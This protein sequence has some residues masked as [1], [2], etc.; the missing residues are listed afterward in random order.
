MSANESYKG[1]ENFDLRQ[2][3]LKGKNHRLAER[4]G[5]F[6][7]YL[8]SITESREQLFMRRILSEA[9]RSVIVEDPYTLA[10]KTMLMFG[11]N[12]YLGLAGH[13]YVKE[14]AR[15]ALRKYGA[16]VGGPPLLN[17][18]TALHHELEERLA[19]LKGAESAL[20]FSSGY[21]ANVGLVTGLVNSTDRVI[22]DA[23]SHASFCDG[24]RMSGVQS[25]HFPH[26]DIARA[27]DLLRLYSG[28]DHDVFVGV[29]GVYSMD[30][31]LA[32][33]DELTRM[34]RSRR[35]ILMVDDAHGTGVMGATGRGTAEHFG[36]EGKVDITMGTFSKAF[37]STGGF[38]ASSKPII[39]YLRFFARS[40]M[41]SAS[42]PPVVIATVLAG[43][44]VIE[45]EPGRIVRLRENLRH[46]VSGLNDMGFDVH[47]A[48]PIIPLRVPP[49]MNI[50]RAAYK[51]HEQ[52]IFMN[53]VEFPAVP[54]CQQRFR[55][56]LM[57]TH[58]RED[59]DR[60][61]RAVGEVWSEC[62][63]E[64]SQTREPEEAE[65]A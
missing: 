18:Y 48:A 57:A 49:G 53:S 46:A 55:I 30:G 47:P 27:E 54:V 11:S 3:L 45:R 64:A 8:R 29:E 9:G 32:P 33:L 15:R 12:N 31:D 25:L 28:P 13:P 42:L 44:D 10:R 14:R 2:I 1:G 52:G 16:G 19:E 36:V 41:F 22:Y 39:D 38:I 37:A 62:A 56:S 4:A 26:N 63:M 51:F 6:S 43:L 58:T 23:Y 40:Y 21:G 65:V 59:I 61:L 20:I 60:L 35:A 17:G 34:C 7:S 5:F 24:V 50:R